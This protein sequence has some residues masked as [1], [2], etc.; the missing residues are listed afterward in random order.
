MKS[1]ENTSK[2]YSE[3]G[4]KNHEYDYNDAIQRKMWKLIATDLKAQHSDP[5]LFPGK[6]SDEL[7]EKMPPIFRS[8]G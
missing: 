7:L 6:A 1:D 3:E 8:T 2:E 5:L 4:D